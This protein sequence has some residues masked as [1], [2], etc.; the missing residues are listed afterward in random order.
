MYYY[1]KESVSILLTYCCRYCCCTQE[2]PLSMWILW[3]SDPGPSSCKAGVITAT[4][5]SV[6][7]GWTQTSNLCWLQW[8][9][10][11]SVSS[12]SLTAARSNWEQL[13]RLFIVSLLIVPVSRLRGLFGEKQIQLQSTPRQPPRHSEHKKRPFKEI[14]HNLLKKE[15]PY[16]IQSDARAPPPHLASPGPRPSSTP[17][18]WGLADGG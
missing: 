7:P 1:S 17:C 9:L 8:W 6:F 5:L 16:N 10:R 2:A 15:A 14:S 4:N 3:G 12:V 18:S 11:C 13:Q